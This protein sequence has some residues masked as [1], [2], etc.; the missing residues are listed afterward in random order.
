VLVTPRYFGFADP[1]VDD[2]NRRAYKAL[3]TG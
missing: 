2:F 3:A 1:F